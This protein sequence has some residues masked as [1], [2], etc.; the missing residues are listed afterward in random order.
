MID[1]EMEAHIDEQIA[2][3][4][5]MIEKLGHIYNSTHKEIKKHQT[6]LDYYLKQKK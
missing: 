6:M 5:E 4:Q 3:R 2:F 1:M